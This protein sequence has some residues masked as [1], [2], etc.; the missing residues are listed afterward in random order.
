MFFSD[1]FHMLFHQLHLILYLY[2]LYLYSL[3]KDEFYKIKFIFFVIFCKKF[4][5]KIRKLEIKPRHWI[6]C[7]SIASKIRNFMK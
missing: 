6:M 7:L 3:K 5:L 2:L 4:G 1:C